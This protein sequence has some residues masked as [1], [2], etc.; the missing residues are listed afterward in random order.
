MLEKEPPKM[1]LSQFSV[2]I[3]CWVYNLLLI[4]VCAPSE[5]FVEKTKLSFANGYQ[6]EISSDQ[7]WSHMS[8][9][10]LFSGDLSRPF[11]LG[12]SL[13]VQIGFDCID[14]EGLVLLV[15]FIPSVL[16][17]F[18]L[19]LLQGSLRPE[20]RGWMETSHVRLSVPRSLIL[21]GGGSLYQFPSAGEEAFS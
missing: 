13:C 7:G 6:L 9:Y 20:E 5:T 12:L 16:K 19:P 15:F 3:F 1:S 11:A 8:V 21:T 14:E 17:L 2:G 10:S 18:Q 4:V